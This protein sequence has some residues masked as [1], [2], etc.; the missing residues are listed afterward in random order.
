MVTVY[1]QR[2]YT[3]I[4]Y[5]IVSGRSLPVPPGKVVHVGTERLRTLSV[6]G[7]LVVTWRR[8]GHTCVLSGMGVTAEELER[9]AASPYR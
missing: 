8:A 3:Q 6:N 4:A 1:Y 5:T 7:R 2:R 9:L